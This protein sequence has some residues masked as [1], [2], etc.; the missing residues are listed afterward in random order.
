MRSEIPVNKPTTL[1]KPYP[2][3]IDELQ[4]AVARIHLTY[5]ADKRTIEVQLAEIERLKGIIASQKVA[6]DRWAQS[7][8]CE[9]LPTE[10]GQ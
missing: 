4:S 5:N 6:L 8:T 3:P 2:N 10:V 7:C 1:G 9:Q